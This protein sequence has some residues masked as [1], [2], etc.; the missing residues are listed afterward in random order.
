MAAQSR[1]YVLSLARRKLDETGHAFREAGPRIRALPAGGWIAAIREALGMSVQDLADRLGVTR[2]S[3]AKLETSERRK[4]IQLD[5]LQRAADALGCDLIYAL[6]PRQ[7]LQDMVDARRLEVLGSMQERTRQH[8]RLEAQDVVDPA[9]DE[10]FLEQ[11]EFLVPDHMLW[12]RK[13]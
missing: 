9:H 4:T 1:N 10:H 3:A 11:A 6:V 8:M 13:S 7:P 5:T 12:R 2:A